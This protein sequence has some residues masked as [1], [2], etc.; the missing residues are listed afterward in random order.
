[1]K[2]NTISPNVDR[3]SEIKGKRK[4]ALMRCTRGFASILIA[5]KLHAWQIFYKL[6]FSRQ[7]NLGQDQILHRV[8]IISEF[9]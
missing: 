9:G 6:F 7:M 8:K 2:D 1:M 4:S 3:R 5:Q